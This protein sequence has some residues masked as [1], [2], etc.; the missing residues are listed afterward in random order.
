M[1]IF[2]KP[3]T[4]L[5]KRNKKNGIYVSGDDNSRVL[6]RKQAWNRKKAR[7]KAGQRVDLIDSRLFVAVD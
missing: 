7:E 5:K 3:E 6:E 1:R 4:R 2:P